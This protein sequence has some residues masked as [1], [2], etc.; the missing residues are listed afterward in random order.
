MMSVTP[1]DVPDFKSET[2]R[3]CY[4]NDGR[5]PRPG[6]ARPGT[7]RRCSVTR[8]ADTGRAALSRRER[9]DWMSPAK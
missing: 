4:E 8:Q 9:E 3:K 2:V 5:S 1:F 6:H 7:F